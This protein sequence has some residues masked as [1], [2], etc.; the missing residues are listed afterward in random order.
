MKQEEIDMKQKRLIG[1]L[2]VAMT[3]C[4][5]LTACGGNPSSSSESGGDTDNYEHIS[6]A[7]LPQTTSVLSVETYRDKVKGAIVGTMAGVGYAYPWEFKSKMWI[8]ES[9]LPEWT[10]KTEIEGY[11]Q[12]DLYLSISAI[13]ALDKLG[14]DATSK[15][16]G[17]DMYNRD[18]EYWIGSNNDAMERGYAPPYSGYPK[19]SA[20]GDLTTWFPDGNSYQCGASFG[21]FLGL[22]MTGYSNEIVE[23]FAEICTYGDGIYGAQVIAAMYG[24]AFFTD[25]VRAIIEAGL[26]AVPEDSWT[27]LVIE[28]T[29]DKYDAGKTAQET[30]EFIYGKY[31]LNDTGEEYQWIPWPSGGILLD[32]KMCTAFTIIGLLYGEGDPLKSAKI[33]VQCANDA[34]STAA[35]SFGIISTIIGYNA[36]DDVY[37]Q[38]ITENQQFKYTNMTVDK[39]VDTCVKLM[40]EILPAQGGKVAY[41]DD[42]LSF[43]IPEEAKKAEIGPYKNSKNPEPMERVTFSE[44][45]MDKMRVL[46]DPGF[47]RHVTYKY[48]DL[49]STPHNNW[50]TTASGRVKAESMKEEAYTGM[51]CML[52]T[53]SKGWQDICQAVDLEAQTNYSLSCMVR[54]NEDF[55][56]KITLFA[57]AGDS[58]IRSKEFEKCGEWTKITINF[59]TGKQTT[60]TVGVGFNGSSS[61]EILRVDDFELFKI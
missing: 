42:E 34:D 59:R 13:E 8:D 5:A 44:E 41:V 21:G 9:S 27:A 40:E 48:T 11:N 29:L 2:C 54:T 55:D 49:N 4:F 37:K 46:Q 45:E 7:D 31:V 14:L 25:D 53:G 57:K 26:A 61:A 52:L 17:I 30:F 16:L 22:N 36:L 33:T 1:V 15:E 24:E 50:T 18:F 23:R 43:V 20:G 35:A 38:G 10:A 47:E 32:A 60:V 19:Y 3:A 6:S 51:T 12:D 28:D 56:S 39:T 58:T